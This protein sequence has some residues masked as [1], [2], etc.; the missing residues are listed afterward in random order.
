MLTSELN[1]ADLTLATDTIH[2]PG[3]A[4]HFMK[5]KPVDRRVRV[6]REGQLLA[7]SEK[8]VRLLELGRDFYDPTL[9]F[10]PEDVRARLVKTAR[11]SHCPLKGDAVYFDLVDENGTVLQPEIAWSYPEP[12]GFASGLEGLIAFYGNQVTV[13]ESPK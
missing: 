6:L 7:E 3:E 5:L 1:P 10:R 2:N 8:A 13:E 9:Y 12:F 11:S 4:R